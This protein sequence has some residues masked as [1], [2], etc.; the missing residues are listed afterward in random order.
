MAMRV[1][2]HFGWGIILDGEGY[3][4]APAGIGEVGIGGT[5]VGRGWK[6]LGGGRG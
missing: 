2:D 1:R 3:S 6:A 5:M 4:T